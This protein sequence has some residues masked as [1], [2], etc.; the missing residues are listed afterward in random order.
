MYHASLAPDTARELLRTAG[1]DVPLAKL[2]VER[3]ERRWLL[4]WA[5]PAHLA[6]L[7]ADADGA[8][9]LDVE[10]RMLVLVA[11]HCSF[12]VPRTLYFDPAN[13]LA[14]RRRIPGAV[15]PDGLYQRMRSDPALGERIGHWL[16]R[17]LAELHA[18][19]AQSVDDWLP[20]RPAWPEPLMWIRDNL[21]RVLGAQSPLLPRL[22]ALLRHYEAL[23]D[24]QHDPVPAH[25]DLGLHNLVVDP[26]SGLPRGIIDFDAAAYVDRHLDFRYCVLDTHDSSLLER[27][28]KGYYEATGHTLEKKKIYLHNALSACSY[29]ANRVNHD[30]SEAWCGR[31]LAEDIA[32]VDAALKRVGL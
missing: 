17:A 16:G 1:I 27:A 21:P 9:Q 29:L 26:E 19:P 12:A 7:P 8:A 10:N 2:T 5:D 14:I 3:R 4:S 22:N 28:L 6:W 15:D 11:K 18:I 24:R 32:W 25:T 30:A 20:T 31:T 13:G 23:I